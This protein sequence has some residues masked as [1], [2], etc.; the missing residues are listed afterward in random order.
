M[1]WP[2]VTIGVLASLLAFGSLDDPSENGGHRAGGSI[3]DRVDEW[4]RTTADAE[5]GGVW[6]ERGRLFVGFTDDPR[7]Y[8][9]RVR[10]DLGTSNVNVVRVERSLR[11]LVE[12]QQAIDTNIGQLSTVGATFTGS[13]IRPDRSVVVLSVSGNVEAARDFVRGHFPPRSVDVEEREA[14]RPA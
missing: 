10:S 3:E 13:A 12:I 11:T 8:E 7:A 1:R 14:P 6:I 5:Y 2:G 4:A 9:A